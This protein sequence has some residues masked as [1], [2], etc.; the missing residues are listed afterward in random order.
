MMPLF[1]VSYRTARHLF[2]AAAGLSVAFASTV[3]VLAQSELAEPVYRV[4]NETTTVLPGATADRANAADA[5]ALEVG[6]AFDFTQ[7]PG[8]HPLAPAIRVLKATLE[9]I[10]QNVHD[11]SATLVKQERVDGELAE[12]Q[13]IFL[14]VRHE[15]FSVYMSFLKPFQGRE[16]LYVA[17]QNN[18][19]MVVLEAGLKRMLGKINLAPNGMVAMRGQK[20]PITK[21]GIRNLTAEMIRKFEADTR[22]AESEVTTNEGTKINGRPTTMIQVVHPIP[23]QSCG[24]PSTTTPTCGPNSRA[25]SRRSMRATPTPISRSTTATQAATS[26]RTIIPRSS[27]SKWLVVSGV[28]RQPPTINYQLTF[29]RRCAETQRPAASWPG[30]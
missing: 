17:G 11:Y 19:E 6:A 3:S 12:H 16:V 14:K 4:A 8:E 23:R 9:H 26:T 2:A 30:S 1:P 27:S 25:G 10:D 18:N 15:P 28:N 29:N 20:H 13:H 5:D 24:S 21:V 7:Q 22:Y